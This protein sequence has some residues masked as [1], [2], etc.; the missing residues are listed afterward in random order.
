V[1]DIEA[2]RRGIPVLL[3]QY[4]KLGGKLLAFN[5]DHNFSNALDGLIIVDL[6]KADVRMLNRLMGPESTEGFLQSHKS[7]YLLAS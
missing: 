6:T 3:K 2:D 7:G 5:V 4:L 1:S